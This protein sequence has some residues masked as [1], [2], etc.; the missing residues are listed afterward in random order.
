MNKNNLL[1]RLAGFD[2]EMDRVEA[3]CC[4][5]CNKRIH[6]KGFRDKRSKREYSISGLCQDC[7][8][9]VFKPY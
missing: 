3:G 4:P 9:E 5:F 1:M 8:D 6:P 2:R 7:Q